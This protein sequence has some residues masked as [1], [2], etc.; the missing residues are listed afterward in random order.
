MNT[1]FI[2]NSIKPQISYNN[3]YMIVAK[4]TKLLIYN[5]NTGFCVSK[6]RV[7]YSLKT[8]TGYVKGFCLYGDGQKI[9]AGYKRGY[10]VIWDISNILEPTIENFYSHG[11]EIDDIIINSES[12]HA[13]IVNKANK[14]VRWLDIL[15]NFA[16]VSEVNCNALEFIIGNSTCSDDSRYFAFITK[17]SIY[18]IDLELKEERE[19]KTKMTLNCIKMKPDGKYLCV[20]DTIGKIHYYYNIFS[21]KGPV[22]S[23]RHWH[24][25]KV[26]VLEFTKDNA[27]LLSGGKEAVVVLWHQITQQNSFISRV[28]NHI[29]NISTSQDGSLIAISMID[30]SVKIVKSQ[31][32]EIVQHFRG[33]YIEPSSIK[34][35]QN[36]KKNNLVFRSKA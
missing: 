35:A 25:N 23:T 18:V 6:C 26:N 31:N 29:S 28:G 2:L 36:S 9:I 34:I 32:Y 22:V 21:K 24:A 4:D 15:N 19:F 11:H 8:K 30:N 13:I 27:F 16:S 12:K 33:L 17:R 5:I 1:R 3:E 20:G 10:V 7:D 14:N